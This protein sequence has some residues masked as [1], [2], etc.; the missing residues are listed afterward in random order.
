[1]SVLVGV[2][3]ECPKCGER[4][5]LDYPDPFEMLSLY[6][7]CMHWTCS[8]CREPIDLTSADILEKVYGNPGENRGG[9]WRRIRDV[10]W[11]P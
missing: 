1:M 8:E 11:M 10:L 5:F 6:Q 9:V 7:S 4:I 2:A 3:F